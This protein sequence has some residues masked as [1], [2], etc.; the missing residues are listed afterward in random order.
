MVDAN[1]VIAIKH[2]VRNEWLGMRAH[3]SI[4]WRS[5]PMERC[6]SFKQLIQEVAFDSKIV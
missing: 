2:L 3:T 6:L 5:P 1:L 4:L